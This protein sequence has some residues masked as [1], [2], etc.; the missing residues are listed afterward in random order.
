M[1]IIQ[2]KITLLGS[3]P[4]IWRR[5][6]M[7][8]H[9]RMDHVHQV[10]QLAMGWTN[11]HLHEFTIKGKQIGMA[12]SAWDDDL[13][14]ESEVY[15]EELKLKKGDNF[16]YTYDFGDDWTHEVLIESI[17][18]GDIDV[19]VCLKGKGACPPEDCGGVWGY[20]DILEALKD[21]DS[22]EYEDFREWLPEG[23]DPAVFPLA[24]INEE[25][26]EFGQWQQKHPEDKSSPWH[27][28]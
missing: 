7:P 3:K 26:A 18:D 10:I 27:V 11:S 25:L 19:P 15:F 5:V 2:F 23:F 14:E 21:P 28:I 13:I 16:R 1:A 8:G 22:P 9:Y 12:E 4:P 20:E 17:E 24:S 6:Q